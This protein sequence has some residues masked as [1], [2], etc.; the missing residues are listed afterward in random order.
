MSRRRPPLSLLVLVSATLAA[1]GC[2]QTASTTRE[3]AAPEPT[4]TARQPASAALVSVTTVEGKV[5]VE[6]PLGSAQGLEAGAFLRI[7]DAKDAD[8]LKGM[9]QV[10]EVIGPARAVARQIALADRQQPLATGDRAL[11]ITDLASIVDPKAVEQAARAA[12]TQQT[13][14]DNADSARYAA[15]RA[16]FQR[17]LD[18]QKLRYDSELTSVRS[19]YEAQLKAS[20]TAHTLDV[21]RRTLA[22]RTDLVAV[23]TALSEQVSTALAAERRPSE[24]RTA[25]LIVERDR[26]RSQLD[27]AMQAQD[28]AAKRIT[29]LVAQLATN[30]GAHG[31]QMRTEVE[32]RELLAGRMKDLEDRLAGRPTTGST[33]LSADPGRGE[34]VLERLT[35]L[36][37]E[38]TAAAATNHQQQATLA[39]TK[40]ALDAAKRANTDL[41]DR[42]IALG[43]AD[44]QA[45]KLSEDLIATR[46]KLTTSEQQ[47]SAL[48]LTRLEAERQLF[49]LA[50]RV[51]RL[52]GS[53]PETIALQAR[54]RDV[55]GDATKPTG[56]NP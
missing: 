8:L 41:Q 6:L 54:L 40:A 32:A 30:D 55:L 48:E 33:V 25:A 15:L 43:N 39:D 5:L 26:L 27:T 17:E 23:K 4:P 46:T 12:S 56:Q 42:L 34:T 31:Q 2:S 16:Q 22:A 28:A 36:T 18:A 3:Q 37:S 24:E 14:V 35:R 10:T 38:V 52:A 45:R 50:A 49:D 1:I 7:Y 9:V 47:R 44:G 21:Q 11:E 20:D 51:L 13:T 29:D 53:S 19:Q